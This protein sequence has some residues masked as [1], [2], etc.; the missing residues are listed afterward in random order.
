MKIKQSKSMIAAR[1]M[2]VMIFVISVVLILLSMVPGQKN[3]IRLDEDTGF[4]ESTDYSYTMDAVRTLVAEKSAKEIKSISFVKVVEDGSLQSITFKIKYSNGQEEEKF[5]Y[6]AGYALVYDRE[7]RNFTEEFF[8]E[9][10]SSSAHSTNSKK[11]LL[12]FLPYWSGSGVYIYADEALDV[13]LKDAKGG[14]M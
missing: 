7:E 3:I 10:S 12:S 1:V 14:I 4:K 6:N 8:S 2:T 11:L 9:E 13:I 5:Y